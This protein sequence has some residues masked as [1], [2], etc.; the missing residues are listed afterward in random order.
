MW[1]VCGTSTAGAIVVLTCQL[2]AELGDV[3][4]LGDEDLL[5]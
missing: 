3:D 2:L 4:E 1:L 5:L